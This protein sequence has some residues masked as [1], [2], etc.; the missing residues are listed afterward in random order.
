MVLDKIEPIT[1]YDGSIRQKFTYLPADYPDTYIEGFTAIK[2]I[3]S[4]NGLLSTFSCATDVGTLLL[5][6]DSADVKIYQDSSPISDGECFKLAESES[7]EDLIKKASI[8]IINR[9]LYIS[10]EEFIHNV[11]LVSITGKLLYSQVINQKKIQ[12]P[13]SN[14]G[15]MLL[16]I[17]YTN[18]N[19]ETQKIVY[20]PK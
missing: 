9:N 6:V 11:H 14:V 18:G 13:L 17:Q 15:I 7:I 5:C 3:G 12:L 8:K 1:L 16:H 2:G 4:T 20:I 19:I 10:S